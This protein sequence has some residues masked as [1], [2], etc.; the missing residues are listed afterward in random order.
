MTT[1][2]A[3]AVK[4]NFIDCIRNNDV[5]R[6]KQ[7]VIDNETVLLF[8][9]SQNRISLKK[10]FDYACFLGNLEIVAWIMEDS[11][12]SFLKTKIMCTNTLHMAI[13]SATEKKHTEIV[14]IL[15]KQL[16]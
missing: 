16:C 1:V 2:T 13:K 5:S 9:L 3:Y 15:N 10:E 11:I 7:C 8:L 4:T 6:A 14:R 12:A